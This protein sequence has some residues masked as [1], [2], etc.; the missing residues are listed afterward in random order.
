MIR[1]TK[2]ND[3]FNSDSKS[4]NLISGVD[5][6]KEEVE[7]LIG[8]QKYSLFFGNNMGLNAE[9]FIHLQNKL[10][11]FNLIKAD[12]ENL[13]RKYRRAILLKTE[14]SFNNSDNSMTI[15]LTVTTNSSRRKP[16]NISFNLNN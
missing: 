5:V 7:F 6:I 12:I 14:M 4:T 13:F 10:A 3:L 8:M 11:T 15:N 16:F 1:G 9:R 2:Y